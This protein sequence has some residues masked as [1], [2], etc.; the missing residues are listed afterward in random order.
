MGSVRWNRDAGEI[1]APPSTPAP[2]E[3]APFTQ[4]GLPGAIRH[5]RVRL[6]GSRPAQFV[7]AHL[8][9][10]SG[11]EPA[12]GCPGHHVDLFQTIEGS[13]AVSIIQETDGC[14]R[15]IGFCHGRSL[16]EVSDACSRI[17]AADFVNPM[18]AYRGLPSEKLE[19]AVR[20]E[21]LH[22]YLDAVRENFGQLLCRLGQRPEAQEAQT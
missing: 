1:A 2:A 7:G 3:G 15:T 14:E 9:R 21:C 5:F 19:P 12:E 20:L 8:M 11:P 16:A 17:D 22:T 18:Q 10:L 6:P 13:F 4:P